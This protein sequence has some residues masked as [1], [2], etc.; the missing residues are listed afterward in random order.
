MNVSSQNRGSIVRRACYPVQL[1]VLLMRVYMIRTLFDWVS[2][3]ERWSYLLVDA[4]LLSLLLLLA[5][6]GF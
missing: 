6:R 1:I 2:S 5:M 4:V 3:F